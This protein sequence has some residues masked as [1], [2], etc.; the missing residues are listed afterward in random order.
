[1][2]E[3]TNAPVLNSE[4]DDLSK[5]SLTYRQMARLVLRDL[6]DYR[7]QNPSFSVYSKNDIIKF[8]SDPYRNAKNLRKAVEYIYIA[9]PHFRRLIDYFVGL[10]DLAYIVSPYKINPAEANDRIMSINYRKTLDALTS[11]SIKTQFGKIIK[12]CLKEDVFFGTLWINKDTI[13]VQQLPS[14]YCAI[15]AIEGNVF[16]VQF[17]F[18]YFTRSR[19]QLLDYY[20]DEFRL[21]YERY[22][23]KLAPRWQE[24]DCPNSFAI[25]ANL[26]IPEYPIP[27]FA[28]LL[29]EVYD[30]EDYRN[31]KLSK[32]ELENYAM[33]AMTLP[34]NDEGEWLIDYNK[35]VEFW[36]NLS[37]VVPP[38]VGTVLTPMPIQK[39]S[40][41]RSG[42][43]DPD[44]IAEAEQALFTAA[45][46]QSLLF[47]NVRASA[48][49]LLLSIK[50]DQEFVYGIVKSIQDMVNR[51]IQNQKYGKNFKVTFLNVSE[52]NRK[53]ATDQYIKACQYGMPF[54]SAYCA[55]MGLDQAEMDSMSY[56]EVDLLHLPD[57][58]TPLMSSSTMSGK[59]L[60]E[61]TTEEG[62]RPQM[63]IGERTDSGEESH[64]RSVEDN[65]W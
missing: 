13:T 41:E 63:D 17:D 54:I 47:N 20:P 21:R 1:M 4:M 27:P 34:M 58:F 37:E 6:N 14:D 57:K 36:S 15:S 43:Q 51:Y 52:F 7:I 25:K 29:R 35:A 42:A 60:A 9:S 28:G 49:A 3:G 45:G 30:L 24:L 18:A 59:Q 33:L 19:E 44:S 22:Q 55:T 56:L 23:K 31:L 61:G 62:G 48:T 40:F 26:E 65:E 10:S 53:E 64:M 5:L 16:N 50:V 8:L 11:M 38:E 39:I 2:D 32:T 46:V 12:V